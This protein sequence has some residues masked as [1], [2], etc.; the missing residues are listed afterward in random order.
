MTWGWAVLWE[1]LEG[2]EGLTRSSG[3]SLEERDPVWRVSRT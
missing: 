1:R 2:G 3:D